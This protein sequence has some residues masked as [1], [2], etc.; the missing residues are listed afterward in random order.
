MSSTHC[1][2][3]LEIFNGGA[4]QWK[5]QHLVAKV[6]LTH[7]TA[8][9]ILHHIKKKFLSINSIIESVNGLAS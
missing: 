3:L 6:F 1:E 9:H 8:F 7:K 4:Q 2:L 5:T